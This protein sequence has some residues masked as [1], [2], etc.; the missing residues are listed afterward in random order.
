MIFLDMESVGALEHHPQGEV[1]NAHDDGVGHN[2][3]QFPSEEIEEVPQKDMLDHDAG[4]CRDTL[5]DLGLEQNCQQSGFH[6]EQFR[7]GGVDIDREKLQ[8]DVDQ[9]DYCVKEGLSKQ[10]WRVLEL[11]KEQG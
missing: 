1:G 7:L 4:V 9:F 5:E 8:T 3:A 6:Q 2:R 10:Q 11:G